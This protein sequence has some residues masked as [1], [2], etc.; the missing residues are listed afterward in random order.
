MDTLVVTVLIGTVIT[1]LL[2]VV[3]WAVAELVE[4]RRRRRG[5]AAL[6][7]SGAAVLCACAEYTSDGKPEPGCFVCRGTGEMIL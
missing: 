5:F 7:R 3:W 2:I 4:R 6:V 1:A